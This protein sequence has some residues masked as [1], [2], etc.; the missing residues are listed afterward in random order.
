M[1]DH[2]GENH[3]VRYEEEDINERSTFWFGFWILAVMVGVSFLVKPLYNLLVARG[4]ETQAPAAYAA[5]ADPEALRP[6]LPRL[7]TLPEV[8]LAEFRAQEDAILGSYAWVE[9]DRGV[10]RIPVEEAM[11]IVAERGLPTF[12]TP[13]DDAESEEEAP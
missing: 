3:D 12:S 13:S 6:P 2:D 5:D 9:K 7:Q 8:D 4:V 1:S 11:R 10:V